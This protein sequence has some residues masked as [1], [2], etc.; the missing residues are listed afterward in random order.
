VLVGASDLV[1]C[2]TSHLTSHY[3]STS[4]PSPSPSPCPV[5]HLPPPSLCSLKEKYHRSAIAHGS[6]SNSC[7][8]SKDSL[9]AADKGRCSET[10]MGTMGQ[11]QGQGQGA[12]GGLGEGP[13]TLLMG[14]YSP[15]SVS[16]DWLVGQANIL[17]D[18]IHP[19]LLILFC[20]FFDNTRSSL[21][22]PTLLPCP[23]RGCGHCSVQ[24]DA[25]S[26]TSQGCLCLCL[27]IS[28]RVFRHDCHRS[29]QPHSSAEPYD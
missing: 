15:G 16:A 23:Q 20:S 27:V 10:E 17:P 21:L 3:L 13:G 9:I 28:L 26:H 6:D 4:P 25:S 19:L 12:I 29:K 11:G 5:L 2:L 22:C 8:S 7:S 1:S 24:Q 18:S 14:S